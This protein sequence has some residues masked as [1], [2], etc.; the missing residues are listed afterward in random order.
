[1]WAK[2]GPIYHPWAFLRR[3]L[4]WHLGAHRIPPL[5]GRVRFLVGEV[6]VDG[7]V[8][9]KCISNGEPVDDS[10][11]CFHIVDPAQASVPA[12]AVLKEYVLRRH[13]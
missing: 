11:L 6:S 10:A 7:S 2:L 5:V 12:G 13:S 3:Q 8:S 9:V 1:V 4:A